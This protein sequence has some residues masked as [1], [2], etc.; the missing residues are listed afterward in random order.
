MLDSI[1]LNLPAIFM[2][3]VF[4][5][6]I[7][8]IILYLKAFYASRDAKQK[9]AEEQRARHGGESVLEWS[10]SYADGEPDSEFGRLVVVVPKKHGDGGACFYEKGLVI[11]NKRLNYADIK[12]VVYADDTAGSV[13]TLQQKVRDSGVMWIYPQKGSAIGIRGLTYRL[14]N[15]T[16]ENIKNGLGFSE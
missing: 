4:I 13:T 11:D 8:F 9:K 7:V 5:G 2:L 15:E 12:D 1:L 6:L 10:G 14:D 16:M 3:L